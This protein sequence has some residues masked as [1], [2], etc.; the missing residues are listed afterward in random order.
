MAS[1]TALGLLSACSSADDIEDAP[2]GSIQLTIPGISTA[3][4]ETRSTPSELGKPAPD[5]F[6]LTVIR[7]SNGVTVYDDA[8]TE[9][10]ITVAPDDYTIT[11]TYGS[12]PLIALDAP[13]YIG[14]TTAT[15]ESTTEPTN[16][17]LPVT[18]GNAVISVIFGE[19]EETTKRFN[20]FYETYSVDVTVGNNTASI[21]NYAP[22]RSAYV[23]A[24][25]TVSLT[26]TGYHKGMGETVHMPINLPEGMSSTLSAAQHLIIT[27][28]LEPETETAVVNVQKA[29]LENMSVEDKINYNWLPRPVVT[30]EH[31]YIRGELVG[32]DLS[33]ASSFPGVNWE[34]TIHQ[35]SATGN[36]VRTLSGQGALTSTYLQN[37]DWPYLPP[38]TYVATYRYFSQQGQAF[39]FD[40]TTVFTVPEADLTLTAE[41]Y[42]S[43][44]K[45]EQGDIAAANACDRLTVYEPTVQWNVAASLLSNS[46]YTKTYTTSIAGKTATTPAT[47][48]EATLANITEVPV[49]GTPYT[50]TVTAELCG[51]QVTA[52]QQVRITGLPVS[53]APPKSTEWTLSGSGSW[54]SNY[55]V[56]GKIGFIF[57]EYNETLTNTTS[58]NIPSGTHIRLDYN[59]V[60]HPA[61]EGTVFSV[62]ASGQSIFSCSES[63]GAANTQDYPYQGSTDAIELY[64]TTTQ[65]QCLNSYGGGQSCTNIYYLNFNYAE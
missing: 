27:L 30:T 20:R 42:T 3:V 15:V 50:L 49:S 35:A 2:N 32:T 24:E 31:R 34:A 29:E 19:S 63:G 44:S 28:G 60:V 47:K 23:R 10:K 33:I 25:S 48:N 13:Y 9:E 7:Q 52:T 55:T 53:F 51:Q 11:A 59:V 12:N 57:V 37:P 4:T 26:F 8:F 65:I 58:I 62:S 5:S 43:Y 64:N 45:Y 41:A 54:E 46:N 61:T 16:V 38:G 14:T 36:V 21:T 18:V 22:Y 39:N 56:L 1:L 40:K 17:T 6:H